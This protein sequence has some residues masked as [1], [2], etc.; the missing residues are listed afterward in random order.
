MRIRFIITNLPMSGS[1]FHTREATRF[2]VPRLSVI[3]VACRETVGGDLFQSRAVYCAARHCMRTARMEM[4]AG[5][6]GERRWDLAHE[7]G[8]YPMAPV[9]T[10]H[11]AEQRLG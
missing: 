3:E 1:L 2:C 10:R 9:D 6:R 8:K 11:L 7:R 4:T 5:R